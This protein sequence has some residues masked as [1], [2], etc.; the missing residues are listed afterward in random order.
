MPI[1]DDVIQVV[2]DLVEQGV[3]QDGIQCYNIH[4]EHI[5]SNLFTNGNLYDNK[6]YASYADWKIE[7]TPEIDP[8]KIEFDIKKP[9]TDLKKI[10]SISTSMTMRL[11]I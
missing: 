4:H 10:D 5:L 7:K 2:N 1:T 8:K 11:M 3:T 6:S 9:E